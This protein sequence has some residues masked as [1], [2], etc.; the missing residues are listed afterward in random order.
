MSKVNLFASSSEFIPFDAGQ[1]VFQVGDPGELMYVVQEGELD[2]LVAGR[3]VETVGEGGVVGEMA[4]IDN[5][6]R[7][8]TVIARTNACA[9]EGFEAAIERAG[10]Y[11]EAGADVTFVEAPESLEDLKAVQRTFK[12]APNFDAATT[13]LGAGIHSAQQAYR[14]GETCFARTFADQSVAALAA[15][16]KTGWALASELREPD[17]DALR[18]RADFQKLVAEVE[19]KAEKVPASQ[20]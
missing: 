19:A 11:I 4:I 17:F 14:M 7:S 18:G 8:A 9:V 10:R 12:L 15:T 13:L 6:P 5:I 3:V 1:T 20:T 2:I 16:V